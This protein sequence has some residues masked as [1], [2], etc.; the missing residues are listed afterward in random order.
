[1]DVLKHRLAMKRIP[2]RWMTEE[3][4]G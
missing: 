1:L 2:E 4:Q 3:T